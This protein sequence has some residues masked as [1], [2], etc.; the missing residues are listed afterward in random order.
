LIL[1]VNLRMSRSTGKNQDS[2]PPFFIGGGPD[3]CLPVWLESFLAWSLA[4]GCLAV[5]GYHYLVG[6][7]VRPY[8]KR[9]YSGFVWLLNRRVDDATLGFEWLPLTT[10]S[11][12]EKYRCTPLERYL[13]LT[14]ILR[15]DRRKVLNAQGELAISEDELVDMIRREE[16]VRRL[17]S[18]A[19]CPTTEATSSSSHAVVQQQ[20]LAQTLMRLWPRLLALPSENDQHDDASAYEISLIVPCYRERGAD[21]HRKLCQ[22]WESAHQPSRI[23][24]VLVD[25]GFCTDLDDKVTAQAWGNVKRVSFLARQGRGPCLNFGAAQSEGRLLAFCH[26]DTQL[27]LNWD[28]TL[29]ATFPPKSAT[30]AASPR[31]NS[32]A[33]GFGIDTSATGLN[34]RA[35]PPGI[36]AV[37]TTANWRCRLW[38]LPYG[39]QCL[40]LPANIFRQLG[41]FPHQC[42]MEDYEL[43]ALL[44]QRVTWTHRRFGL[45]SEAL[46]ILPGPP[47]LCSPRR[48]QR[49][50]VLY[51]TYMNS[52][53]VNLYASGVP[54]EDIYA[55]YYGDYLSEADSLAP[56]EQEL[57]ERIAFSKK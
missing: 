45:P 42:F 35:F 19:L 32:C 52:R 47:A 27:P 48:W 40:T 43:I 41:G 23:Q 11:R 30:N 57:S 5:S 37:E 2:E 9:L 17:V 28:A 46:R 18:L 3:T 25:A 6:T 10:H 50:G 31:A 34:G 21:I 49:C 29:L 56:W 14:Q 7:I 36:R 13:Q 4:I 33:F 15:Q 51:V 20:P 12:S 53:L 24:L 44:R 39:D 22:A 54:P 16:T 1:T 8:L 55:R 26:S 38:S